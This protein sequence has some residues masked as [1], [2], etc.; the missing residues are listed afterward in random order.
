MLKLVRQIP[1]RIVIQGALSSR[2]GF[3]FSMA[4][5]FSKEIDPLTGMSV[6]LSEV[7]KWLSEAAKRFS[8]LLSVSD[9]ESVNDGLTDWVYAIK[10]FLSEKALVE[11][12]ELVS[13]ELREERGWAAAWHLSLPEPGLLFTYSHYL[14]VFPDTGSFDLLKVHF[15]WL[16]HVGCIADCQYE[17][18]KILKALNPQDVSLLQKA[19]T[20][21][22]GK[23]VG[24]ESVLAP[25]KLQGV[26]VEFLGENYKLELP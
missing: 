14:E 22:I 4:A 24:D 9:Y 2:R 1:I 5:G 16:R 21:V 26:Q 19:L 25:T 3:L 6:N 17:G 8:G 7:D 12:A 15:S 23:V 10:S 20:L 13:L 11:G 18:F